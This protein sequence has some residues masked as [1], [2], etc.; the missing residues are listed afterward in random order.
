[1]KTT[2]VNI[3]DRFGLWTVVD[4][5]PKKKRH[6]TYLCK[7]ECGGIRHVY[8]DHLVYGKSSGCLKCKTVKHGMYGTP[9]YKSWI[10]MRHRCS[11]PNHIAFHR[12]GG[13]G[14]SVCSRWDSFE[15]FLADM[16][17]KPIGCSLDRI[18]NNKG[19]SPENCRWAS[20]REQSNNTKQNRLVS[21]GGA[22]YTISQLSEKLGINYNTLYSRIQRGTELD[23]PAHA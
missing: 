11:N 16:G 8:R 13:R 17:K 2:E 4:L 15:N 7:C 12:Y 18:D 1:M 5:G 10:A 3:G 22:N 19:Y 6:H 21:Y 14:I 23:R 9:E 20:H